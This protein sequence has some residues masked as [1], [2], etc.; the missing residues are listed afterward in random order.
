[1]ETK[2]GKFFNRGVHF[3]DKK[4]LAKDIPIEILDAPESVAISLAQHIGKPADAVVAVGDKVL[5]GQLI[6]KSSGFVSANVYSSVSGEVTAIEKKPN[7]RGQLSAHIVIKNDGLYTFSPLPSMP[8]KQPA[9]IIA[10][11]QEAGIVGLG[12]AG[13]PTAVKLSPKTAVDTLIING[14]ECEPYLTCDFRLMIEK[15][16]EVV[17]GIRLL[18][19]ALKLTT[20][21]VGIEDNKPEAIA[22]FEKF[23]DIQV[24]VLKKRYPMGSEKHLIYS[25]TGRKVPCGKLPSDVGCVVQNI[26]TAFAVFDA[27]ELN[28]PLFER[29]LTVS[30][31]NVKTPKNLLVKFGTNFSYI[32]EKCS[33]DEN[34]LA[35]LICGGPMMGSTLIGR[36]FYT[37]KTD[38]GLL[39]LNKSTVALSNP[40]PCINCGACAKACPMQLMPMTIDFYTQAGDWASADKFGGVMN[41]IECGSCA[42]VCPAKRALIQSIT[43]CKAK[44]REKK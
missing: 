4:Y 41:C 13:F 38:S 30:G 6:G 35:M 10:R 21:L 11:V 23:D 25:C 36:D 15:T 42:F 44:L 1:M 27:V 12:G 31:E 3:D 32:F 29:T 34:D 17:Q 8:D 18:A 16:N 26:A 5:Q 28:K 19:K 22:L 2:K 39:A 43:L 20:I 7:Q 24:V 37:K 9:T 40:T 33:L 14:A